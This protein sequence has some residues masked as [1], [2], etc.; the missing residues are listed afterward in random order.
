[1]SNTIFPVWA[2][3]VTYVNTSIFWHIFCIHKCQSIFGNYKAGSCL[4]Q[5]K[6]NF[7]KELKIWGKCCIIFRTR[8]QFRYRLKRKRVTPGLVFLPSKWFG[9][10]LLLLEVRNYFFHNK[11]TRFTPDF[12][13]LNISHSL[14]GVNGKEWEEPSLWHLYTDPTGNLCLLSSWSLFFRTRTDNKEWGL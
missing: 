11:E 14:A 2:V 7:F 10:F 6:P 12:M 8:P 1:M 4:L 3:V 9:Y 5:H 13:E